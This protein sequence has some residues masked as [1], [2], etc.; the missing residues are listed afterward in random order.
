MLSALTRPQTES[1]AGPDVS[2]WGR[3][4]ED[5]ASRLDR[6]FRRREQRARIR[7]YLQALLSPLDRKN[8]W[9]IA[10]QAGDVSPDQ[11][12]RFVRTAPWDEH[13]VRDDLQQYVIEHLA[14]PSG[15]LVL[16]ETGFLKKGEKSAGVQRQYSGTAGRIENCQVGVFLAYAGA[17]GSALIDREL[18]LPKSWT[19]DRERCREAGISDDVAFATKPELARQML[20]RAQ[21]AQVTADWVTADEVYGGNPALRN[22]LRSQGQ[23]YVMAVAQTEAVQVAGLRDPKPVPAKELIG[24]LY[25]ASWSRLSAGA[26]SK[27]PRLY[28]WTALPLVHADGDQWQHWLLA[29]RQIE[30]P[31]EVA[32]YRVFA[33]SG[34]PMAE[35]VRVAGLRWS[36]EVAFE[37]AKQEAGLDEYEV[38]MWTGWYR[39]VT[40][41]ML[42]YAFLI[43]VRRHAWESDQGKKGAGTKRL[44]Q[45]QPRRSGGC[46]T[47]SSGAGP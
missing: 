7:E 47:V 14:D 16:D 6:R 4:F 37:G 23:P 11:M 20:E 26:G 41:S 35:L 34:T 19:D 3:R 13:A 45:L 39:H 10:E 5:L 8:G 2:D 38:R 25:G 12:Q 22:W 17:K 36:I 33:P 30:A 42:A 29:R 32:Y 44:F 43:V 27:G 31:H 1:F 46:S 15:V 18:Y 21:A 28:D 9:Q 40:L 24:C